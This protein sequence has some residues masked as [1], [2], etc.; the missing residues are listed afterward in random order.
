MRTRTPRR[1]HPVTVV[2]VIAVVVGVI[3][4]VFLHFARPKSPQWTAQ[5]QKE[6][7]QAVDRGIV[8]PNAPSWRLEE[9]GIKLP[10]NY[11]RTPRPT[12]K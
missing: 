7:Q 2:I 8:F 12:K 4:F 6:V 9:L 10:P 1:L 11:P 3:T 5:T